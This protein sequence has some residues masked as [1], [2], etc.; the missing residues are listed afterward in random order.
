[1]T[2]TRRAGSRSVAA[3]RPHHRAELA[4]ERLDGSEAGTRIDQPNQVLLV[5]TVTLVAVVAVNAIASTW[6]TALDARHSSAMARAP[7]C[8][9]GRGERR[10][11]RADT[12]E[13]IQRSTS[14]ASKRT[15]RPIFKYGTRRSSISRRTNR[16]V[17]PSRAAS[18]SMSSSAS[19]G[20]RRRSGRGERTKVCQ[21][22]DLR[23]WASGGL[24]TSVAVVTALAEIQCR[25]R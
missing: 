14:T 1:V 3:Q 20:G 19:D 12:A 7:R 4:A 9:A 15:N 6:A 5:G 18:A 10:A 16:T 23:P 21:E 11:L 17:T 25:V 13:A 22:R 8:D 24:P 2:A